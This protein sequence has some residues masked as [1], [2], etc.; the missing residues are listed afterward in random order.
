[1]KTMQRARN[2]ATRA[3]QSSLAGRATPGVAAVARAEAVAAA[4]LAGG[5]EVPTGKVEPLLS[6]ARALVRHAKVNKTREKRSTRYRSLPPH[7]F[8]SCYIDRNVQYMM[9]VSVPNIFQVC[10]SSAPNFSDCLSYFDPEILH[11]GVNLNETT[12]AV[13]EEGFRKKQKHS[14]VLQIYREEHQPTEWTLAFEI[15]KRRPPASFG[16][17]PPI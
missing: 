7:L 13:N 16:C 8:G 9:S 10:I 6:L 3:S 17:T 5:G 15:E 14:G 2:T 4:A 12:V 1:M 11:T